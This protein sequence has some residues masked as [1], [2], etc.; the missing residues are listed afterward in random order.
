[1]QMLLSTETETLSEIANNHND[2]PEN[3]FSTVSTW[4]RDHFYLASVHVLL[5]S[6]VPRL[7]LIL[8]A[9]PHDLVAP[10]SG[11]Y[12]ASANNLLEHGAFLNSKQ[13]PEVFRTP[14]YPVFLLGIMALTGKSLTYGD[15]GTILTVQTV[16]LSFSVVFL[17]WLARRILPPVMAFTGALL[18]SFSP[19]GAVKA[20]LPLTEGLFLLSL[21]VLFFVMYL[22]M[23]HATKL[24]AVLL[25]GGIVGLLTSAAVFVRPMWPLVPLVAIGFFVLCGDKRQKALILVAVMLVCAATPLCFWKAR[26]LREA[27]FDGLSI[28][29]GVNAYHY[30]APNVKALVKGVEGDRWAMSKISWEEELRWSQGLSLQETND[31]RWRRA[32]AFFLEHPLLTV[33]TFALNAGEA[34]IHPDP[35]ILKPPGLNFPGDTWVLGGLWAALLSLAGLGLYYTPDKERDGGLIQGK[36]LV[37]LLGVC[38][39][40]T[41]TSGITFGAGSRLR[42]P[43]ELI[44]PL[45]AAIG[46]VRL[47]RILRHRLKHEASS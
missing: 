14:G 30:L 47:I 46:L 11:T 32:N 38:L 7:F 43:L 40:L 17:Y 23:E 20:G 16:I 19:W 36:W 39:L 9:D 22:V 5:A 2:Q 13:M 29:P 45:L 18:A 26:N 34:I 4:L 8:S 12:F 35:S 25:G 15:L 3:G 31:E 21:A 44:V 37:T 41:L 24:H 1:M 42:A 6:L 33:Y 27:Q 28:M 10:D